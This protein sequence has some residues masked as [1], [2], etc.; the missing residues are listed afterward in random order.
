MISVLNS[1]VTPFYITDYVKLFRVSVRIEP[2]ACDKVE[3][4]TITLSASTPCFPS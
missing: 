3:L 2:A 4:F 1:R